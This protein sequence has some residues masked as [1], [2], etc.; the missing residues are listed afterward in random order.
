MVI[1]KFLVNSE[2]QLDY[3]SEKKFYADRA[4]TYTT[5]RNI[6]IGAAAVVYVWNVLDAII[7]KGNDHRALSYGDL[8]NLTPVVTDESVALSLSINF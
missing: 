7:A 5:V 3:V 1:I 4:N 6:G 8:M 2:W